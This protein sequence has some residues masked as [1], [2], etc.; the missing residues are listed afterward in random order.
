MESQGRSEATYKHGQHNSTTGQYSEMCVFPPYYT[1]GKRCVSTPNA[2]LQARGI[3]GA[4][5]ERTLC[6]VALQALVSPESA[7]GEHSPRAPAPL[8]VDRE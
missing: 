3:A 5:D 1:H 6:P 7:Q 8:R 2:A 4:R